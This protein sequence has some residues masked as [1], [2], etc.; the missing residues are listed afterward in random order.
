[1]RIGAVCKGEEGA[2]RGL[3]VVKTADF[4]AVEIYKISVAGFVQKR[5][6]SRQVKNC[7]KMLH[8]LRIGVCAAEPGF[9]Q[10][11]RYGVSVVCDGE[12]VFRAKAADAALAFASAHDIRA[13]IVICG[14]G[15]SEVTEAAKQI[16]RSRRCV[17]VSHPA[18]EDIAEAVYEAT[19]VSIREKGFGSAVE[20]HM[21]RAEGFLKFRELCA[22]FSDFEITLP[23][24]YTHLLPKEIF[25]QLAAVLEM[26]G[27]LRKN[28]IKIGYF[29]K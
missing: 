14:G 23:E 11:R 29:P 15:F 16:L 22:S 25:P 19:G 6:F 12:R 5:R 24:K 13:D 8:R 21:C 20:I 4:G 17:Y 7:A 2:R 27:F 9:E 28:E 1:M 10:L 3:E 26:S 18:F